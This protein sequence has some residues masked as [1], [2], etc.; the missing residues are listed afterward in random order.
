MH[1]NRGQCQTSSALIPPAVSQCIISVRSLFNVCSK[2]TDSW[3]SPAH[4]TPVLQLS[5][6]TQTLSLYPTLTLALALIVILNLALTLIL[7]LTPTLTLTRPLILTL[8]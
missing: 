8:T 1:G 4:Q 3:L 5:A 2:C 6:F 7:T